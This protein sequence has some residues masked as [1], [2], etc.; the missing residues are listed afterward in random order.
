MIEAGSGLWRAP[1]SRHASP[2]QRGL[3]LNPALSPS[4]LPSGLSKPSLLSLLLN[5]KQV[6]TKPPFGAPAWGQ[7]GRGVLLSSLSPPGQDAC[8]RTCPLGVS[9]GLGASP[10]TSDIPR[11]LQAPL[12]SRLGLPQA[13]LFPGSHT[14]KQHQQLAQLH[15]KHHPCLFMS[16]PSSEPQA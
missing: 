7:G 15:R 8:L 9:A 6:H 12:L 14:T 10:G 1:L 13:L 2:A 5:N 3:A 11:D 16:L 4:G